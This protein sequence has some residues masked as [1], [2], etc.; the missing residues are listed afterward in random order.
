[1]SRIGRVV[2]ALREVSA[3]WTANVLLV[4]GS[5]IAAVRPLAGFIIVVVTLAILR[6]PMGFPVVGAVV[7]LFACLIAVRLK[8]PDT[9]YAN[10]L[11]VI[12]LVFLAYAAYEALRDLRETRDN[13]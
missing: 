1:M 6:P 2:R 9:D 10:N 5:A 4:A 11:T 7:L 3:P 8:G 12:I 13:V